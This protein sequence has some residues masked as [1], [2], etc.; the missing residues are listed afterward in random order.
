MEK[1]WWRCLGS[2]DP[3]GVPKGGG[4][5]GKVIRESS[6]VRN[7]LVKPSCFRM[8]RYTLACD[9]FLLVDAGEGIEI[10]DQGEVLRQQY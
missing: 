3:E 4:G 8:Q 6:R 7:L 1:A 10:G 5:T 9:I 2:G